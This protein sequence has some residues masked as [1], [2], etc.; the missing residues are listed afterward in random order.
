MTYLMRIFLIALLS[1]VFG[2]YLGSMI[3]KAVEI[4]RIGIF[5]QP[6]GYQMI[7]VCEETGLCKQYKV[8][9]KDLETWELPD[10]TEK[11]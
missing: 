8:K 3:A 11:Q 10:E 5:S 2:Y 9:D 7:E 4:D 1:Y 6:D